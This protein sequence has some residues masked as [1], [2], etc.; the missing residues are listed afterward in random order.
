MIYIYQSFISKYT[1]AA[2]LISIIYSS[3]PT[4]ISLIN[5][6][7]NFIANLRLI[8]HFLSQ[9]RQSLFQFSNSFIGTPFKA[10]QIIMTLSNHLY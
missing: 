5:N 3:S 7:I 1:L 10:R 4:I 8:K 2:I 9:R 6:L